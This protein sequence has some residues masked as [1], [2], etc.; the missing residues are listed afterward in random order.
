MAKES[1]KLKIFDFLLKP[2]DIDEAALLV[3]R[4]RAHLA[5]QSPRNRRAIAQYLP[6]DAIKNLVRVAAAPTGEAQRRQGSLLA[7]SRFITSDGRMDYYLL[8][9]TP[10]LEY[11]LIQQAEQ[12]GFTVGLSAAGTARTPAE[13]LLQQAELA[14]CGAF[15]FMRHTTY[16]NMLPDPAKASAAL[17]L[18]QSAAPTADKLYQLMLEQSFGIA[19]VA[20]LCDTLSQSEESRFH[21]SAG[22][23][24][25]LLLRFQNAKGPPLRKQRR[26]R[27]KQAPSDRPENVS[28]WYLPPFIVSCI[29]DSLTPY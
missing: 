24:R 4:L 1:I 9:D 15:I 14:A 21:F 22:H 20:L 28:P 11:T 29:Q 8:D 3:S 26:P 5:A 13:T 18:M 12:S 7:R 27:R 6:H 23:P 16:F 2:I 25:E 17:S 10:E 19:D